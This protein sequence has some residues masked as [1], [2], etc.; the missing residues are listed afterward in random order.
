MPTGADASAKKARI[1]SCCCLGRGGSCFVALSDGDN[2]RGR[3]IEAVASSDE[4][5]AACILRACS[6]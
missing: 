2:G 3:L 6:H 1:E 4:L 5:C